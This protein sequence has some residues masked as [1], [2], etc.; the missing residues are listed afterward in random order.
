MKTNPALLS[1]ALLCFLIAPAQV[2]SQVISIE[3]EDFT[4]YCDI[5]ND[6]INFIPGT[7]CSGGTLLVGL[8]YPDEWTS[9]T[10]VV[11]SPGVYRSGIWFR[12]NYG[13]QYHLQLDLIPDTSGTSQT[14]DFTFVGNGYG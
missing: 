3:A 1:I 8:D 6:T 13:L 11:D 12:G 14:I 2:C 7:G 9:Y 10:T 4:D 5:G